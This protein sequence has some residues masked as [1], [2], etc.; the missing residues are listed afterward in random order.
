M[1]RI[2]PCLVP[3]LACNLHKQGVTH[4]SS[5]PPVHLIN[6]EPSLSP[7]RGEEKANGVSAPPQLHSLPPCSADC[8]VLH[9]CAC[10]ASSCAAAAHA[11]PP[12]RLTHRQFGQSSSSSS[13]GRVCNQWWCNSR[14]A[15]QVELQQLL[16]LVVQ[17]QQTDTADYREIAVYSVQPAL[18]VPPA[19]GGFARP[20]TFQQALDSAARIQYFPLGRF[21]EQSAKSAK[22]LLKNPKYASCTT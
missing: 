10:A 12:S 8:S 20:G 2:L 11:A 1:G 15:T 13:S 14:K 17:L 6:R 16:V 7:G 22:A 9:L 21:T 18:A 5:P 19:M 4:H 3:V